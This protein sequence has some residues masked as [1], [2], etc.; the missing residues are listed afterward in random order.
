VGD[1]TATPDVLPVEQVTKPYGE[2]RRVQLE[3]T[4]AETVGSVLQR[5]ADHFGARSWGRWIAFYRDDD[6]RGH[7]RHRWFAA[8]PV[9]DEAGRV[10]WIWNFNVVSYDELVKSAEANAVP[11]DVLSPYLILQPPIGDGVLPSWHDLIELVHGLLHVLEYLAALEGATAGFERVRRLLG[12]TQAASAALEEHSDDWQSNGADP[13]LFDEWLDDRPWLAAEIAP[14]LGC[15]D[16]EAEAVLWAFGFGRS[17]SGLW[18]RRDGQ[19]AEFMDDNRSLFLNTVVKFAPPQAVER[20]LRERAGE[21][22][23]SGNAPRLERQN[24]TWLAPPP[25][26][27]TSLVGHR[28]GSRLSALYNRWVRRRRR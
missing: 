5:A 21:Y 27:N 2:R 24:V 13:Y 7:E 1:P 12:R 11:G 26:P 17:E 3:V 6:D 9:L 28:W 22:A 25:P 20:T 16:R 19:E 15:T 18:R 23:D 4:P 14:L 10:R 8:L